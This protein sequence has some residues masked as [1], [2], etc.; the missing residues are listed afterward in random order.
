MVKTEMDKWAKWCINTM[1]ACILIIFPLYSGLYGNF[2]KNDPWYSVEDVV[3]EESARLVGE[4]KKSLSVN[5]RL[6]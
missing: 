1:N 2:S 6:L 5:N 4:C 3:V